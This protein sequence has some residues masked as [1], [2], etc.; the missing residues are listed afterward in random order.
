MKKEYSIYIYM[1]NSP[2]PCY[3][4]WSDA[5]P[6][7][8]PQKRCPSSGPRWSP[9][10]WGDA[11]TLVQNRWEGRQ[12]QVS[13]YRYICVHIP[14]Y[15][16]TH[17]FFIYTYMPCSIQIC[18]SVKKMK[19]GTCTSEGVVAAS[20]A[21]ASN[22]MA[23]R[24]KLRQKLVWVKQK[25]YLRDR[26]MQRIAKRSGILF[27]D[28]YIPYLYSMTTAIYMH[29]YMNKLGPPCENLGK[30]GRALICSS[31][32][33]SS[34]S[35]A[36][37]SAATWST[38]SWSVAQ[39]HTRDDVGASEVTETRLMARTGKFFFGQR[40]PKP[41]FGQNAYII[42]L[43]SHSGCKVP[44]VFT[45]NISTHPETMFLAIRQVKFT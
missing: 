42:G 27:V 14:E 26:W 37:A 29:I 35:R 41:R 34:F 4:W 2:I 13:V 3:R 44:H 30:R 38:P 40:C 31:S 39:L 6:P 25:V 11:G 17:I 16:L 23:W 7:G 28:S 15:R 12:K 43:Y 9:Q 24:A 5:P 45:R 32:S 8:S 21:A 1:Y 20:A 10:K 22:S 19:P 33:R 18:S 36:A